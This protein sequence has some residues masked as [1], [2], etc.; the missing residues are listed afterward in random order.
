[1]IPKLKVLGIAIGAVFAMSAMMASAA[2][3][4]DTFTREG[5]AGTAVLTGEAETTNEFEITGAGFRIACAKA[6]FAGTF[7]NGNS[8]VTVYPTYYETTPGTKCAA[9]IGEA[10]V[11]MNG[12]T[13]DLSGNTTGIDGGTDATIWI[14]C[15][16]GKSIE[17]AGALGCTI[18]VPSQTPTSGGV[19]YV[20]G[21]VGGKKDVTVKATATGITYTSAGAFCG[22][23]GIPP[24]G[25]DGDYRGAITVKGFVDNCAVGACPKNGDE[26]TE[27]NQIGIE[28]SPS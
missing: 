6:V 1:M 9:T 12:C 27:G 13:Y 20:N 19:T 24:H 4:T 8:S 16:A 25:N 17:I 14:S 26:F 3:A 7:T 2:S 18:R 15:P 23:V 21:T 11:K 10:A 5:G 28:Y 22:A